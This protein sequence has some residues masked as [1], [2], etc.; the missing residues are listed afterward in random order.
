M[1]KRLTLASNIEFYIKNI[2]LLKQ[3]FSYVFVE[4]EVSFAPCKQNVSI[5]KALPV[6]SPKEKRLREALISDKLTT[7]TTTFL[8]FYTHYA[9]EIDMDILFFAL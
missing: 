7:E 8:D 3:G 1:N 9:T 2:R 4:I 5:Y 6:I